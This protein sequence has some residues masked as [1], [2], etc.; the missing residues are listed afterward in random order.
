[1]FSGENRDDNKLHI[2]FQFE[3]V[4]FFLFVF[5]FNKNVINL[6]RRFS[7]VFHNNSEKSKFYSIQELKSKTKN[8]P[9]IGITEYNGLRTPNSLVWAKYL[10]LIIPSII[11]FHIRYKLSW[12]RLYV[13]KKNR[14]S[15]FCLRNYI[16]VFSYDEVKNSA[17]QLTSS[18]LCQTYT[19]KD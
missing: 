19:S 11:R 16:F 4:C 15:T 18:E 14:Y 17:S 9:S 5:F 13:V 7:S 10:V 6:F 1:M 12:Y 2:S 3:F 8:T